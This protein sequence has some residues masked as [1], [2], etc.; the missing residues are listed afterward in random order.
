MIPKTVDLLISNGIVLTM[1]ADD[2][3]I[4]D[5]AVAVAGDRIL[6]IGPLRTRLSRQNTPSILPPW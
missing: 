2:T 6:A 3:R 4:A 5:G 1:D